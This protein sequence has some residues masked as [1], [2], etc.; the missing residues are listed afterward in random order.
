MESGLALRG[1][2]ASFL[3]FSFCLFAHSRRICVAVAVAEMS[4]SLRPPPSAADDDDFLDDEQMTTAAAQRVTSPP[5]QQHNS[6]PHSSGSSSG[7]RLGPANRTPPLSA[8]STGSSGGGLA[9]I[10]PSDSSCMVG[11][12][13]AT[14]TPGLLI[15]P[16]FCWT[17]AELQG[18]SFQ[19]E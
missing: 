17:V 12:A 15:C 18:R 8:S 14:A 11:T 4:R 10:L 5:L 7:A 9:S 16:G 13:G 6:S 3:F 1:F 2:G 19:L